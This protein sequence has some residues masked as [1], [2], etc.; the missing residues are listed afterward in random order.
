MFSTYKTNKDET[1]YYDKQLMYLKL[2][3]LIVELTKFY[4]VH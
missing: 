2:T 3:C 1:S 4:L